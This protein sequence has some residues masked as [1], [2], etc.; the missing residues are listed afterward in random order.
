MGLN[1]IGQAVAIITIFIATGL[2]LPFIN[3]E[4]GGNQQ[5]NTNIDGLNDQVS[6]DVQ[7]FNKLSGINAFS[8]FLSV[9]SMFFWSFGALPFWLD[10]LFVIFRIQLA[11]LIARNIWIGGGG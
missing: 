9:V 8:V 11:L 3:E 4:L 6:Q 2:I 1:D 7:D 5:F 10:A